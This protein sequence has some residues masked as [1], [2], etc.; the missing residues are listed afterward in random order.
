M[1]FDHYLAQPLP[2][3]EMMGL[4]FGVMF[5]WGLAVMVEEGKTDNDGSWMGHQ[6][7]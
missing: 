3:L 7:C 5:L 4:R 2:R 1:A 6:L